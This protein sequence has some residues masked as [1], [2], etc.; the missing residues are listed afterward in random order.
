[1]NPIRRQL[2]AG[3][4]SIGSWFNLQCP[5]AAER[6]GA[7]GFDWVILDLQHRFVSWHNLIPL[8]QALQLGGTYSLVRVPRHDPAEIM[9]VLDIG[10]VGVVVPLVSTPEQ[11]AIVGNAVRYPPHGNRSWGPNRPVLGENTL[12]HDPYCIAMIETVEGMNNLDAIAA[13]PG[14]DCLMLG[15]FDLAVDMGLSQSTIYSG[16]TP[17]EINEAIDLLVA[18]CRRH[19]KIASCGAMGDEDGADLLERGIRFL[20]VG[21]AHLFLL[22]GVA[23][24]MKAVKHWRQSIGKG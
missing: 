15:S 9:G 20:P 8:L 6:F 19:G 23:R 22:E 13:T 4:P 3:S 2:N 24:Q 14:I 21:A 1:M 7:A 12:D 5:I 11:A 18:A 16:K 10:A 17:T